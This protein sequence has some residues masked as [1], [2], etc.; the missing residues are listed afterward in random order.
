[1]KRYLTEGANHYFQDVSIFEF[2]DED[3]FYY[4]KYVWEID[5]E[6][7]KTKE[8]KEIVAIKLKEA[9]RNDVDSDLTEDYDDIDFVDLSINLVNNILPEQVCD[10]DT[11]DDI[12]RMEYDLDYYIQHLTL[13]E[14]MKFITARVGDMINESAYQLSRHLEQGSESR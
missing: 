3:W 14:F 11:S 10:L 12:A 5:P 9:L 6:M 4:L 7:N 8:V 1:M 13:S 2:S